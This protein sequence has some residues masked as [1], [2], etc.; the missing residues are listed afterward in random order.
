MTFRSST[1]SSETGLGTETLRLRGWRPVGLAWA[2]AWLA[3]FEL[4]VRVLPVASYVP[5]SEAG[6]VDVLDTAV[7]APAPDP[8]IVL[9]GNSRLRDA[10]APRQLEERL[11]LARGTVL[12]LG[13]TAGQPWDYA[14]L[15]ERH[16]EKLSRARV[17]VVALDDFRFSTRTPPGERFRRFASFRDRIGTYDGKTPSLVVGW[18]WKTFDLRDA[19][20]RTAKALLTGNRRGVPVA[21]DGRI[22]W[23]DEER[24]RGPATID[25]EAEV[26]SRYR[27]FERS[28]A[29][30]ETVARLL[31]LAREDGV[32]VR[33]VVL[34]SRDSIID[35]VDR[36]V[37]D[38]PRYLTEVLERLERDFP[39]TRSIEWRRAS[40][41]G[42]E[43]DRFYDYGHLT[44]PGARVLTDRLAEW[45]RTEALPPNENGPSMR[46]APRGR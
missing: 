1:S 22:V 10:V 14:W 13:I 6:I 30:V 31:R 29:R 4:L 5:A 41:L 46:E 25:D 42:I 32:A 43:D 16:R 44:P 21:D 23:R 7:I 11:G 27:K 17:L 2:I 20:V 34:P 36:S 39:G 45:L 37:P 12:N 3:A 9:L 26:R 28:A 24:D 18:F 33:L 40:E 35:E 19:I 38:A 8:A 15:Y